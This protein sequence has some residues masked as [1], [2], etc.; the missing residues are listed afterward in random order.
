MQAQALA[1]GQAEEADI[2]AQADTAV[3]DPCTQRLCGIF[4]HPG[5]CGARHFIGQIHIGNASS[6]VGR[7]DRKRARIGQ[8]LEL[9]R[10]EVEM[11]ATGV[12]QLHTQAQAVHR[13]RYQWAGI[14]RHDHGIAPGR[15]PAQRTQR[16]Q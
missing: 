4:D 9:A 1:G 3:A 6:Q 10:I 13:D 5:A 16:D 8:P 2:T 15:A 14:G 7:Q 11:T 12:A